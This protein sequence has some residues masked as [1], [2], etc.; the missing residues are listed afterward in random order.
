M[1]V[2]DV[3]FYNVNPSGLFSTTIGGTTVYT[4]PGTPAGLATITDT[5]TGVQE[6]TL[7]D[8]SNG[9]ETATADVTLG[10]NTSIGTSVDAELVWTVRDTVTGETFQIIQFDVETGAAAGDYLLS[11]QP[12]VAGRTYVTEQYNT[13]PDVLSGDPVFAQTDYVAQLDGVIDGT[14]G[15]DVIDTAYTGDPQGDRVDNSDNIV[16]KTT[17]TETFSWT[18]FGTGGTDISAGVSSTIGGIEVDVSFADDGRASAFE[19][20]TQTQYVGPGENIATNSGLYLEGN[21]NAGSDTSTTTID[22]SAAAGGGKQDYVEDVNFRINEIDAGTGQW[23]D[24]VTVTAFDPAGNPI[25]VTITVDGND[26]L[27][28]STV[29]GSNATNDAAADQNSSA[30]IHVAGPVGQIVIDYNNGDVAGQF[31]SV[32]DIN[33]TTVDVFG[34]QDDVVNAGAGDDFV[35]TALGNDTVDGGTGDDTIVAGVGNDS[36]QGG[37][38]ADQF[39]LDDGFGTDTIVGGEGGTDNDTLDA[40]GLTSGVTVTLSGDEAGTLTDGTSTATFSEI[41]D[42][43]L[44]DQADTFDASA[45]AAPVDVFADAGNDSVTGSSGNDTIVAGAG[46]DTVAGGGG[47]DSIIGQAG[48]DSI[49]GGAGNDTIAGDFDPANTVGTG[50]PVFSYEYYEL[51][52]TTLSNLADAG[53]DANGNNAN[54]PTATGV[55]DSTNPVP[56]DTANG[57]NG[58]TFGVKL[59]TT[60]TVTTGGTYNFDLSGDDGIIL[61]IDGVQVVNHDGLHGTTTQSGSTT[62]SPGDHVVEIIY[63]ENF[64]SSTLGL[65]ISGPDTGGT[66]V[67]IETVATLPGTFNDTIDGGAGNDSIDGG[68]G[69]DSILGGSGVDTINGGDG[70]DTIDGGNNTDIISGGAGDDLIIDTG[71]ALSD[72]TIDGGAGND[73]ING[74]A[75]EDLLSGGDDADTFLIT[76][77]FGADTIIGGEGGTDNDVIDASGLTN[78]ITVT[79]S[80]NEQ[81]SLTDGTDTLGFTEIEGFIFT[82]QDDVFNGAAGSDALTIDTGAGNDTI[83]GGSGNDTLTGGAGNDTFVYTAGAGMDT[84]TDFGAGNTGSIY[85]GD[86]TN[87]DLVD[88]SSFYNATSLAAY[89][90]ANGALGDLVHEISLLRADAA[91]GTL[92]GIVNGVDISGATGAIDLTLLNGGSPVT[93]SALSFDNTNVVCFAAGTLIETP[94]GRR[95]IEHLSQGDLV[96]TLDHG[97][98]EIRWIGQRTVRGAGKL[99]PIVITA[100]TLDNDRDLVV[101][102][103]HRVLITG[104]V[105]EAMFGVPEVL[106]AAKHLLDWDGIYRDERAEITYLHML[107]D[108]HEI[109]FADGTAAESFHPGEVGLSTLDT[110]ALEEIYAIFPELRDDL[111]AYGPLARQCL[112]AAAAKSLVAQGGVDRFAGVL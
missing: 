2:Y 39:Q 28:G 23:Q 22:F 47:A 48:A 51:D 46:D 14:A 104:A 57:G 4:G 74:G 38:G 16:G 53:F 88:L 44:T 91:D 95:P 50:T 100:Q 99:A 10:A 15:A 59:T 36:L 6:T 1:A 71:G 31:L 96:T 19:V 7:D 110:D 101:S 25:P 68:A 85:D 41:E 5:E 77:G 69:A 29:T 108:T 17:T 66:P 21:G 76:D 54:T 43:T 3:N 109:V 58:D 64:G 97:A 9:G 102:P 89:N 40:T 26:S 98:Q 55:T 67:A 60:L 33:F 103:L 75:R 106:V 79:L 35:N 111:P 8:D 20:D 93:G 34:D 32:T 24:I 84:I 94:S 82:D 90:A 12:L 73:T 42:F 92:D 52:G 56:I 65:D 30:F 61:F 37:D 78:G 62:L 86:Q 18:A 87:N 80:G 49:D 112:T 81:G 63:F 13:N 107:F 11:E 72:D 27:S 105:A 70:N 45:A 83:T